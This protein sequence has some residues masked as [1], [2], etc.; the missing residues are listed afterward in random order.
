VRPKELQSQGIDAKPVPRVWRPKHCVRLGAVANPIYAVDCPEF[1][2]FVNCYIELE[3]MHRF[4]DDPEWGELLKRFRE[5][6]PTLQDIQLIN[7]VCLVNDGSPLPPGIQVATFANRERDAINTASFEEY[8]KST[9]EGGVAKQALLVFMDNLKLKNNE[10]VYVPLTNTKIKQ[11]FWEGCGEDDCKRSRG[12]VDP[13]L[14]LYP[15]CPMMMTDN[16][17]VGAG[18]ANGTRAKVQQVQLKPGEEA[19]HV[20]LSNK[21]KVPVVFASQVESVLLKHENNDIAPQ[22]FELK[23][24][25]FSFEATIIADPNAFDGDEKFTVA[26]KGNQLPIVSNTAT[27]GHKLQGATVESILVNDWNYQKNWAYVVMSRVKTMNG[28]RI[29]RKLSEDMS[30]YKT[31][32]K[33]EEMLE[34]FAQTKKIRELSEA[35]YAGMY[36]GDGPEA[37]P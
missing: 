10:K 3:G 5:G 6:R 20:E 32:K 4:K 2:N 21:T 8:C 25:S 13:V 12:R 14:K 36:D 28:L 9:A 27:T 23:P 26:M 1:H 35:D 31:A 7:K 18:R 15:D 19:F 37:A 22:E 34:R 11:R 17:N 30:N 24:T 29:R 33:L 16:E